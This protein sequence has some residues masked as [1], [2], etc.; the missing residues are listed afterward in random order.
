MLNFMIY[1]STKIEDILYKKYDMLK[2]I[3][4]NIDLNDL[5]SLR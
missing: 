4:Y 5:W 3:S 1:I 2:V